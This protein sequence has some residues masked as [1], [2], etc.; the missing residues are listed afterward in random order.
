MCVVQDDRKKNLICASYSCGLSVLLLRTRAVYDRNKFI[1]GFL[2]LLL[3]GEVTLML[4]TAA[5]AVRA[6]LY[7]IYRPNSA[8]GLIGLLRSI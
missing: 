5:I 4:W 2:L 6:C 8:C 3:L 1:T 7:Y